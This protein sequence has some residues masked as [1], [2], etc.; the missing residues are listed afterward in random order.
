MRII[1]LGEPGSGKGT[2]SIGLVGKYGIPPISTGDMLRAAV[3]DGTPLGRQAQEFM[4]KGDLVPDAVVMDLIRERL[5]R[6]DAARGFILD[7]FPRTLPQAQAL[8]VLLKNMGMPLTVVLKMEVPRE[9]LMK[10]LTGR[11]VCA[12]CGAVFNIWTL[13]PKAEG[14]CDKCGKALIQR[15]DDKPETI[16]NRLAVYQKDT[17]PLVRFYEAMGLL[18]RVSC[19]VCVEEVQKR[20][21][22]ALAAAKA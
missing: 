19:D 1:L 16:E 21:T 13:P 17:A 22:Q 11:R 9:V 12:G 14:I 10:R 8:E 6:E 4:K 2:C 18:Q 5:G 7:G 20:L 15:N 3:K